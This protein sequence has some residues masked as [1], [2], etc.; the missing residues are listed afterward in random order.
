M[1]A[2]TKL[3]LDIAEEI[4]LRFHSDTSVCQRDLAKLYNISKGSVNGVILG[5][6][7]FKS[8]LGKFPDLKRSTKPAKST[9][10]AKRNKPVKPVR[11]KE[12]VAEA[13]ELESHP[14]SDLAWNTLERLP[15]LEPLAALA[16]AKFAAP[17]M[18]CILD[19]LERPLCPRLQKILVPRGRPA[20]T[21]KESQQLETETEL[22]IG[23]EKSDSVLKEA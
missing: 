22:A 13:P 15:K 1:G 4:F 9:T 14:V 23:E 18:Y 19:M 21:K 3:S 11:T 17:E 8:I 12:V 5:R 6:G 16:L 10:T 20:N 7:R 2:R